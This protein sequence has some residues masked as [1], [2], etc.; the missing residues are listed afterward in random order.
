M[1][2]NKSIGKLKEQLELFFRDKNTQRAWVEQVHKL[3]DEYAVMPNKTYENLCT[4][5]RWDLWW[6]LPKYN[7]NVIIA[8]SLPESEWIGGHP[9]I[10]DA[11]IDTLLRKTMT[12]LVDAALALT[13]VDDVFKE[14]DAAN[15][16]AAKADRYG[17][18]ITNVTTNHVGETVRTHRA[19]EQLSFNFEDMWRKL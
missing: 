17:N 13:N 19:E 2:L 9:D 14:I 18:P 8:E 6:A 12:T 3:A 10:H 16:S 15:L 11:H 7:R 1:K 5:V 4:R